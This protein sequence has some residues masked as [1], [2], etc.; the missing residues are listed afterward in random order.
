MSCL[1]ATILPREK[2]GI[3]ELKSAKVV[4]GVKTLPPFLILIKREK[5]RRTDFIHALYGY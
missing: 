3:E 2:I 1:D 5:E 4:K